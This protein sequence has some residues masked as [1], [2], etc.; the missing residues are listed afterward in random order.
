M[1]FATGLA[2]NGHSGKRASILLDFAGRGKGD[3]RCYEMSGFESV[4]GDGLFLFQ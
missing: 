3:C 2:V 1:I 4:A